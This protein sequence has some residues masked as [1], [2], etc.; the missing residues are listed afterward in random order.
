VS[1]KGLD[2]NEWGDWAAGL[3]APIAFLWLVLGYYQQGQ[4]L[5]ANVQA[6]HMQ[7]QAL[8]LQVREL[9]ESVGQQKEMVTAY[10]RHADL[11]A[12]SLAIAKRSADA[13]VS[14]QRPWLRVKV[15]VGKGIEFS[16]K[17][18]ATVHLHVDLTNVGNSPAH[19]VNLWTVVEPRGVGG[20]SRSPLAE[21]ARAA[22]KQAEE[23]AFIEMGQTLY[24]RESNSGRHTI[25]VQREA[26]DAAIAAGKHGSMI[27]F[28]IAVCATYKFSNG[29]EGRTEHTFI[30]WG[31]DPRTEGYGHID[32]ALSV[33]N[34]DQLRLQP[35]PIL[36][37]IV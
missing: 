33:V 14:A 30:L 16:Q 34:N 5:R 4:E 10:S 8:Q 1:D 32:S 29:G 35:M 22:R 24:P 19:G 15:E 23:F 11:F 26:L 31:V 3:A 9:Q 12:E 36:N 21:T 37:V 13:A 28:H 20:I 2:P 17:Q 27:L 7:E 25:G 6:L 18:G